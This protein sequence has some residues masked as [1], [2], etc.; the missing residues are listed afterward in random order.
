MPAR[1]M[2]RRVTMPTRGGLRI[3]SADSLSMRAVRA[4]TIATIAVVATSCVSDPQT[5]LGQLSEARRLSSDL[6]VQFTKAADAGNLSVMADTDDAS[7][8]FAREAQAATQ[9]VQKGVDA[10]RPTLNGLGYTAEVGMLEEFERRFAAYVALDENIL[11]LAVE[12]TNLKAQRLSFGSG[13]QAVD[14]FIGGLEAAKRSIAATDAWHAEALA[15]TAI[16]A[17]REIQVLQAPHIAEAEESPMTRMEEQMASAEAA[18]RRALEG[19]ASL[20]P[21]GSKARLTAAAAALDQFMAVN[22]QIVTLSRRNSNVRSLAL[23][24]GQKRMLTAGCEETLH[25]LQDSLAQ[26]GVGGSR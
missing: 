13:P 11:G 14:A 5:T 26:R 8:A 16:A 6:L 17:V 22:A 4:A 19:L 10:L 23:A 9:V 25:A 18:A 20:T 1:A 3:L 21:D 12:N 15:A 24:L 7:T 2:F